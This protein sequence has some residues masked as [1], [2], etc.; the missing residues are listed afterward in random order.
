MI[1]REAAS[2]LMT[3]PTSMV[4]H[5]STLAILAYLLAF[6]MLLP[7]QDARR[8]HLAAAATLILLLTDA[9]LALL[10]ASGRIDSL[11]I[12]PSIDRFILL[13]CLLL[14]VWAGTAAGEKSHLDGILLGLILLA[15]LGLAASM[16]LRPPAL[17]AFNAT[18]ADAV[19]AFGGLLLSLTSLALLA[20]R[21]PFAWPYAAA[22]VLAFLG[23]YLLHI[24]LGPADGNLQ[25]FVRWSA[26]FA[27]PFFSI[28][29][30]RQTAS[31]RGEPAP[32]QVERITAPFEERTV[33][34]AGLA[35][36]AGLA[37]IRDISLLSS[38]L[39]QAVAQTMKIEYCLLLS[40][41]DARGDFTLA[42][43]YDLIQEKRIAGA[44]LSQ[45]EC[46]LL[47]E[48]LVQSQEFN[49]PMDG[50][51]PDM[52]VLKRLLDLKGSGPVH[53][54]PLKGS[55]DLLGGLLLVSPYARTAFS[56]VELSTL[57]KI[58]GHFS[59]RVET[60]QSSSLL[61]DIA[62]AVD[63]EPPEPRTNLHRRIIE[64]EQENA[65]LHEQLQNATLEGLQDRVRQMKAL[66]E[67]YE[68]AQVTIE[69]L[70]SQLNTIGQPVAGDTGP[71]STVDIQFV[72]QELA[73][74]RSRIHELEHHLANQPIAAWDEPAES[75][76]APSGRAAASGSPESPLEPLMI[77]Q[78]II[79]TVEPLRSA[80]N[81]LLH[82]DIA[83]SLPSLSVSKEAFNH[84]VH[85]FLEN[86]I[87]VS[88][89]DD[90]IS[91]R[92]GVTGDRGLRLSI[93]DRGGGI[94]AAD[95]PALLTPDSPAIDGIPG[96]S[97]GGVGFAAVRAQLQSMQADLDIHTEENVGTTFRLTFPPANG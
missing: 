30:I 22:A 85:Y 45:K 84:V 2:L 92:A 88:A 50:Q 52:V 59:N 24:T 12:F 27:F 26:L 79:Q 31:P 57:R 14:L 87:Q 51:T 46:P 95:I 74:A 5:V 91:L 77:I 94:P 93:S 69:N 68:T 72:L 63:D 76:N 43:G 82:K 97:Q 40:L 36:L 34:V 35:E 58:S 75:E 18:A 65:F 53:L 37:S 28:A 6:L 9:A 39:V 81:I 42:T 70:E 44:G 47:G 38:Q 89:Q 33:D 7:Q 67:R 48:A 73:E 4:F 23:G 21:R 61:A 62:A 3:A 10:A 54:L 83:A 49:L 80:K 55:S 71:S 15:L 32:Q 56:E 29:A 90:V 25:G 20:I 60:L 78:N 11:Y 8:W 66:T 41:P 17:T 13:V 16:I 86:A 64:L 1:L 19:W 96:L